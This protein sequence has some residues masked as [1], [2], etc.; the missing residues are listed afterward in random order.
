DTSV[1]PTDTKKPRFPGH[2]PG[3]VGIYI[4]ILGDMLLYAWLFGSFM[5]YRKDDVELFNASADTLH[6]T[7][8]MVNTLLLLTASLFVYWGIRAVRERI[9]PHLAPRFFLVAIACALGFLVNKYFEYSELIA[10]GHGPQDNTFY[11]FYF[12]LTGIHATH[13]LGG[14]AI[15]VFLYKCSKRDEQSANDI[16]AMEGGASFW[17][18]VDLLWIILFALLFLVR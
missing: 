13:L 8:G 15:L 11:T 3:E 4:F 9:V 18:V 10:D 2:I 16:R 14:T 7:F 12:V 5:W 1:D 6:I 17:H